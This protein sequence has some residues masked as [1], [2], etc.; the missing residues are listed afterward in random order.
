MSTE[1]FFRDSFQEKLFAN[2]PECTEMNPDYFFADEH[3]EEEKYGRSERAIAISACN[4]CPL[5][6]AC[7]SYAI[8]NEIMEGVWGGSIPQQR[9][10]YINKVR[11]NI[12]G[13]EQ[14][15]GKR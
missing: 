1:T 11:I 14:R 5:K 7:F 6:L 2:P 13:M 12:R 10:T 3:D 15:L 9:Q 4:R 8:E